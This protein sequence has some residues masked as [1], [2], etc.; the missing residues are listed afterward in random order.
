MLRA[1][2]SGE[3][4]RVGSERP[5]AVNVRV[6]A[7]TNKDL[8][9]EVANGSFRDDLY[10]RLNVVPIRSPALRDRVEDIP[11][12]AQ[13]FFRQFCRE[14]GGRRAARRSGGVRLAHATAVAGQR[15]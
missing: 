10:F 12:L 6:L 15:A 7:A 4:T 9:R 11:L 8:E 13:A 1:L 14:Y 5:I 2:Q 3:I